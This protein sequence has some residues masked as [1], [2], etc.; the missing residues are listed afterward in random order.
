MNSLGR[1]VFWGYWRA[2]RLEVIGG[3][4]EDCYTV[5]VYNNSQTIP[6]ALEI[7]LTQHLGGNRIGRGRRK[8]AN[9]R[10]STILIFRLPQSEEVEKAKRPFM[11]RNETS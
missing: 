2:E 6:P 10:S 1:D 4:S 8:A 5:V 9:Q 3:N 7:F 11:S